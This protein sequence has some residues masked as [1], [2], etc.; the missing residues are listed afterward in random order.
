MHWQQLVEA[1][2]EG[3]A[4]VD[5]ECALLDHVLDDEAGS[6]LTCICFSSQLVEA[7]AI[8]VGLLVGTRRLHHEV[9]IAV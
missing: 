8:G 7:F 9:A 3:G 6:Q 5:D 2:R 4:A 1:G